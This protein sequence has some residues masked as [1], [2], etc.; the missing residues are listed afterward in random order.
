M[1]RLPRHA[2][3]K[4]SFQTMVWT[5]RHLRTVTVALLGVALVVGCTAGR[6]EAR[7]DDTATA[8]DAPA[9]AEVD[10]QQAASGDEQPSTSPSVPFGDNSDPGEQPNFVT[11]VLPGE[12]IYDSTPA[13]PAE[14]LSEYEITPERFAELT[15]GKTAIDVPGDRELLLRLLMR[16]PGIPLLN[17]EHW[18]KPKQGLSGL[19]QSPGKFRGRPFH[20]KGRVVAVDALKLAE[21]D[22]TLFD[23]DRFYRCHLLAG[24][25]EV[26]AVVYAREIP[27]AWK[28][29]D[30]LD[31]AVSFNGLFL[32]RGAGSVGLAPVVFV[33]QRVAWHPNSDLG[34]LGMDVGLL[35]NVR[36]GRPL[37]TSEHECFYQLLATVGKAGTAELMRHARRYLVDKGRKYV[38]QRDDLR[39]TVKQLGAE[40]K[41]LSPEEAKQRAARLAEAKSDLRLI[42]ARIEHLKDHTA[43]E[44]LPLMQ[45]PDAYV[46]KLC[47][48]R[49]TAHRVTRIRVTDE[50]LVQRFGFDQYYQIDLMVNL[51]H[52]TKIVRPGKDGKPDPNQVE[53]ITWT[54]PATFCARSLPEGMPIGENILEPIRFVGFFFKNWGYPTEQIKDDHVQWQAAPMFIGREPFL[55]ASPPSAVS[56][57]AGAIAAGLF[58]LA[59]TSVWIGVW[60]LGRGDKAF[61]QVV[62]QK[63]YDVD[64]GTSLNDLNWEVTS[65]DFSYLHERPTDGADGQAS[66]TATLAAET[67]SRGDTP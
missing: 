16:L 49:G 46:G 42:E 50:S 5:N 41:G 33:A 53:R 59:L 52:K 37:Q 54:H 24:E 10:E 19:V 7:A 39:E 62:M 31:E 48:Y 27:K 66:Q 22:A 36:H 32:K 17:M 28:I 9:R 34:D 13:R 6:G 15:D 11:G 60:Q 57:Y 44:F 67:V 45:D 20:V 65:V 4:G 40:A 2:Q 21:P 12:D 25:P 51:E 64:H 3:R 61:H 63:I 23:F 29:G 14:I 8:E 43:D 38:K 58:V 35:E 26:P 18:S 55:E 47:M 30:T 1:N 56:T